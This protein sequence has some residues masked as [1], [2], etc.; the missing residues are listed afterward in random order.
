MNVLL[1][2]SCSLYSMHVYFH[3]YNKDLWFLF[4]SFHNLFEVKCICRLH[5][6]HQWVQALHLTLISY[7][8]Y[9]YLVDPIVEMF[10]TYCVY[11][12]HFALFIWLPSASFVTMCCRFGR[13]RIVNLVWYA[14]HACNFSL[15]LAFVE[16]TRTE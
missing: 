15:F 2:L 9:L 8:F 5:S 12:F 3:I 16:R 6:Q 1:K 7:E 4:S 10:W 13:Y 11:N 14:C